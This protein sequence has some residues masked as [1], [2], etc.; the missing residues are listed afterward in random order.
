MNFPSPC[1]LLFEVVW[2]AGESNASQSDD[3]L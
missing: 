1:S 3:R 2:R